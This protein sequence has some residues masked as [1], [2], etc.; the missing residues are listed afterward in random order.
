MEG[1][2]VQTLFA[3]P[4]SDKTGTLVPHSFRKESIL[5]CEFLSRYGGRGGDAGKTLHVSSAPQVRDFDRR[6]EPL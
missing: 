5:G 2:G 3:L 6:Q 1:P 4:F